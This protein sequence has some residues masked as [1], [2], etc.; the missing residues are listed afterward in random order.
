MSKSHQQVGLDMR[1]YKLTHKPAESLPVT[2][3]V[4]SIPQGERG[5]AKADSNDLS[6]LR[7]DRLLRVSAAP[8]IFSDGEI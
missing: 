6:R 5:S 2:A 3:L 7:E 8:E 1:I 4:N